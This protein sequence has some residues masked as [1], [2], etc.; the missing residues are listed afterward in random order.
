[1]RLRV[2][3]EDDVA[4]LAESPDDAKA[5][6]AWDVRRSDRSED[7]RAVGPEEIASAEAL[8]VEPYP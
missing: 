3:G 5:R 1:V 2:V 4:L 7:S 6:A 8:A